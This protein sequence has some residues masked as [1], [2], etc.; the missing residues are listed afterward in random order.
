M[1]PP[2]DTPREWTELQ[3]LVEHFRESFQKEVDTYWNRYKQLSSESDNQNT[4]PKTNWAWS[5]NRA[6]AQMVAALEEIGQKLD[7][8]LDKKDK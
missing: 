7:E 1:C 6:Y 2:S 4:V 8:A 3:A 5:L